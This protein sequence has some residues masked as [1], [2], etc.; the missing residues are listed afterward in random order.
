[1][2]STPGSGKL[3]A[4]LDDFRFWKR[5]RTGRQIKR[6]YASDIGGGTNAQD[7]NVSLGV[8]Y[9]FNE[10]I[11]GVDSVDS[12]ILDYSG[13]ATNA[14]WLG[15]P[16]GLGRYTTSAIFEGTGRPEFREPVLYKSHP[17]VDALIREKV[18]LAATQERD[19]SSQ[20][21]T[22]LPQFIIEENELD[23]PESDS[24]L[25]NLLNIMGSYFDSS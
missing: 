11:F 23:Q 17:A 6:W 14:T 10:G 12:N 22:Y 21:W 19:I 9:K 16:P 7:P 2:A 5:R 15:K 25:R 1:M 13:R 20:L 18:A 3:N 4:Y 24:D 8:Y